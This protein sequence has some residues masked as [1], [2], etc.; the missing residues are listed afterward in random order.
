MKN[1][2]VVYLTF[3]LC[4]SLQN[5]SSLGDPPEQS[6]D[7]TIALFPAFSSTPELSCMDASLA[8][9][10]RLFLGQQFIIES[11]TEPNSLDAI[12]FNTLL[13]KEKEVLI[14]HFLVR[15]NLEYAVTSELSKH[16]YEYEVVYHVYRL[17][18]G[19]LREEFNLRKVSGNLTN[20]LIDSPKSLSL[21]LHKK[22]SGN[23]SIDKSEEIKISP[24]K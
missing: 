6:V 10:V 17:Q 20:A 19:K 22:L 3:L 9:G 11:Y 8:Y 24:E 4:L 2:G 23:H 1:R 13:D 12:T 14:Q 15:K 7:L 16:G 5:S 18:N 21:Q